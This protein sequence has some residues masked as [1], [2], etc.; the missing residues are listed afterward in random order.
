MKKKYTKLQIQE[1][2]SYWKKQLKTM[3]ESDCTACLI[4]N[5]D[6]CEIDSV[7]CNCE[8]L[9]G[10]IEQM[11]ISYGW[12]GNIRL[13]AQAAANAVKNGSYYTSSDGKFTIEP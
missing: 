8:E 2:I 3:N 9:A 13:D 6:D 12:K 7:E 10:Q 1:A 4:D 11:M 5:E